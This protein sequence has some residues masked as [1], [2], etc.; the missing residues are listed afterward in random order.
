MSLGGTVMIVGCGDVG[1]WVLEFL[2]RSAG[3]STIVTVDI[4]EDWG[5]LKTNA[6]AVGAGH[7][8]YSKTIR[9]Y[10]CDVNDIN[11]T[12]DL[13][14]DVKPDLIFSALSML[15]FKAQRSLLPPDMYKKKTRMMGAT[16]A[17]Q[18]ALVAKLMRAVKKSGITAPVINNSFSDA[19]NPVLWR[20]GLGPLIGNG[21]LD[22]I[23]GE[24]RR[25]VSVAENV[26]IRDVTVYYIAEHAVNIMGTRTGVPYFLKV[27]VGDRNVTSKFDVDSLI[28]DRLLKSPPEWTTWVS[29]PPVASGAVRSILAII[30][31]TNLFTHVPGPNG[32]PGGYP[33]RLS[34]KGCEVALPEEI[35]LEEAIKINTDA[36]K[37]EGIE[38]IRGDG[39]LVFTEEARRLCKEAY[40]ID[41]GELR[42]EDA[43]D[44]CE[45][46]L[47]IIRR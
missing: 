16:A 33:V 37:C 45:E 18:L 24:I 4:R 10:K 30:N 41:H 19:V 6:A 21:N 35:T 32:L 46:L 1:G 27:M 40:G 39:T 31:D 8:G 26:P 14:K 23:V 7:Q 47:S 43:D 29:H 25:K 13:L 11:T 9:F 5:I 28:S 12:V 15:G 20:N 22:T 3:V 42:L 17:F 38:E 44:R 2:A 36:M 34:A